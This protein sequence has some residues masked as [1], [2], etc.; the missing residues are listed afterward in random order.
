MEPDG[1]L[2]DHPVSAT[3]F[4]AGRDSARVFTR[5]ENDPATCA[6]TEIGSER[7]QA[8][9]TEVC[10]WDAARQKLEIIKP[11]SNTDDI[12]RVYELPMRR[13]AVGST[14]H[15]W[16]FGTRLGPMASGHWPNLVEYENQPRLPPLLRKI[17]W[18]EL[19]H[20]LQAHL[21]IGLPTSVNTDGKLVWA[22]ST[23]ICRSRS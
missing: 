11:F 13:V 3:N 2:L 22:L 12:F 16:P 4:A 15:M 18:R 6:L 10:T 19:M 8:E 5:G 7:V 21:Q 23:S 17:N 1:T 14:K 20:I 9:S